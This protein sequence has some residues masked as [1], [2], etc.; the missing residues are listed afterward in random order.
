M[1]A[2]NG[3]VTER[4]Q[5]PEIAKSMNTIALVLAAS[6]ALPAV[7]IEV[8]EMSLGRVDVR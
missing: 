6:L 2:P 1:T 8:V 4:Q 7:I 3:I 5:A